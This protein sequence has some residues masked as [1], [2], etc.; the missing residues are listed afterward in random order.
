MTNAI[1]Y[2]VACS[3]GVDS[4]VLLHLMHKLYPQELG[5]LHCNFGL[6]SN[7]SD[8]DEAFVRNLA[9]Q[10]NVPIRVKLFDTL[11]YGQDK[12]MNT[13][14][15]ARELRYTWFEQVIQKEN[16]TVLLAHHYDDQLETFFLQLRRGGKVKGLSGM[17]RFRNG[18]LRP[19][20]NHRKSDLIE[21]AQKNQWKWRE[22]V[23]NTKNDYTRNWYRN[24]VLFQLK[25]NDFP[26]HEVVPLMHLFQKV[27][28]FIDGV[29][30]ER[31][32][33][34]S[35][36]LKLPIWVK[37]HL[38]FIHEI[39]EYSAVE[40]DRLA[41]SSK[42]KYIGNDKVK[43]WNEGQSLVFNHKEHKEKFDTIKITRSAKDEIVLND[44]DLFL[45]VKKVEGN[46]SVRKWKKGDRFRPLGMKGEK[47]LGK[48]LRDRK[49]AAHLKEDILV[50]VNEK[51][52]IL[53]VFGFGVGE[54]FKIEES[55]RT[56]L[57]V[58]CI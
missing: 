10:L 35:E 2:W 39:G 23:S 24:Q 50:L 1:K 14:L 43:V 20:L 48:F 32:I 26:L 27:M 11:Q 29:K 55:T 42:G 52:I 13:Q 44:R 53:G 38:L 6:R 47:S 28:T 15:A 33:Q 3:G 54:N 18:Y 19:L 22:D 17:P 12:R 7:D 34:I 45:D 40:I 41:K 9:Q 5:I 37:D 36:W 57:R 56:V 58:E 31:E 8:G 16:G 46:L 4:V 21:L 51:N 49:V 30:V 25:N